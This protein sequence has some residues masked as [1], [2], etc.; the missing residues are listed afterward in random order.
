[1]SENKKRKSMSTKEL[2]TIA[3]MVALI[4]VV[5][6][7]AITMPSG[8]PLTL[9]TFIV[10]L[11]GVFLYSKWGT[12]SVGIYILL[13]AIGLPVF[14]SYG[15]GLAKLFGPTGGFIFG[16]LFLAYFSGVK[17]KR[18]KKWATFLLRF[19]ITMLGLFICHMLGILWFAYFTEGSFISSALIVSLP[20]LI[21]DMISLVA[22]ISIGDIL[23][24]RIKID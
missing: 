22:A 3:M 20:Y 13:G 11:A 7:M 16:F 15:S 12:I 24:K 14:S 18:K 17:I 23:R 1:M 8:V 6:P 10:S 19:I 4:S 2:V 21:K 5:S 9:Q